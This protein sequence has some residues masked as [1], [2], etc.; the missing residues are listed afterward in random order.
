V[1]EASESYKISNVITIAVIIAL[2][3]LALVF[4]R[5]SFIF[6]GLIIT[7]SGIIFFSGYF[8]PI[9]GVVG[10]RYLFIPSL[11]WCMLLVGLYNRYIIKNQEI[12]LFNSQ[13]GVRKLVPLIIIL[14]IYSGITIARNFDW[15]D[16]VVLMRKDIKYVDNSAQAHNLLAT[17]L[18]KYSYTPRYADEAVAM[19]EEAAIH[20]RKSIE[21]YPKF[22]NTWYDLAR[23]YFSLNRNDDALPCL[24]GAHK[25]DS[26]FTPVTIEIARQ[27]TF[28]KDTLLA[29]NYY[30]SA[31]RNDSLNRELIDE[32]GM[33]YYRSGNFDKALKLSQNAL[34][35]FPDWQQ[36][37][38]NEEAIKAKLREKPSS[39]KLF[40]RF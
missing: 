35:K 2:C 31:L 25:V 13:I 6:S 4:F 18:M 11:G 3:I 23:V 30:E 9:A 40:Q 10:D 1:F 27:Y 26:T 36:M 19:R 14:V 17:N 12:K 8:Y 22:L 34:A 33:M 29:L 28:R 16:P 24:L 39:N 15:K 21:I 37:R 5:D 38:Q 20:F 32:L 7:V